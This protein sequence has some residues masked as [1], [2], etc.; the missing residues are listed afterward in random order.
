MYNIK[1]GE[2]YYDEHNGRWLTVVGLS[3][4]YV[5]CIVDE[6]NDYGETEYV[7]TLLFTRIEI[8]HYIKLGG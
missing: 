4:D 6:L 8:S 3:R 5:M 1:L 7:D 2:C